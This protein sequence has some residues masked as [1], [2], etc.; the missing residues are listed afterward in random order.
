MLPR[1][2]KVSPRRSQGL[3]KF[4]QVEPKDIKV[5]PNDLKSD[6]DASTICPKTSQV[7]QTPLKVS[8]KLE[9]QHNQTQDCYKNESI[10]LA[11]PGNIQTS[12]HPDIECRE[13]GGRAGI[14]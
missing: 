9:K 2:S 11:L 13:V 1:S 10:C 4:S 3:L 14:L 6:P 12:K 7:V 8:S 5:D